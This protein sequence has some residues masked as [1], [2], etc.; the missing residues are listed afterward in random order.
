LLVD[1]DPGVLETLSPFFRL[2]GFEVAVAS[3]G[4]AAVELAR[5]RTVATCVCDLRLLDISGLDV[6]RQLRAGGSNIPF[7]LISGYNTVETTVEAM[8]LG[9]ADVLSKPLDG[10]RAVEAVRAAIQAHEHHA[11]LDTTSATA[12][13]S[14]GY[15]GPESPLARIRHTVE[16]LAAGDASTEAARRTAVMTTLARGVL[17]RDLD[18]SQLLACAAALRAIAGEKGAGSERLVMRHVLGALERGEAEH[19]AVPDERVRKAV[20]TLGAPDGSGLRLSEHGVGRAVGLSESHLG[21][22]LVKHTRAGFRVLRRTLR[23]RRAAELLAESVE[24]IGEI[25][26]RVGYD[27][28]T[29]FSREFREF[30]GLC[31]GRFRELCRS[32][33]D[34]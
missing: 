25:G 5:S 18:L 7:L 22:L 28:E 23:M 8:K 17:S 32:G 6:L 15:P 33:T 13:V 34:G 29:Q 26:Y 14:E 30:F 21:R 1:D 4:I 27:D 19:F 12:S 2:A 24:H 9:A 20:D 11:R 31:P 16:M 3:T 10:D